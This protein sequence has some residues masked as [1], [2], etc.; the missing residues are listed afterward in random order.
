[1][2]DS[3]VVVVM[4]GFVAQSPS[5]RVKLIMS[6][7]MVA[8]LLP[9]LPALVGYFG[10]C[11]APTTCSPSLA[12]PAAALAGAPP[13]SRPPTAAYSSSVIDATMTSAALSSSEKNEHAL[14]TRSPASTSAIR[15]IHK[16]SPDVDLAVFSM[17]NELE[18]QSCLGA[19]H[20]LD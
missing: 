15:T 13:R 3:E 8:V 16:P 7:Y 6:A 19:D 1:M 14:V 2:S 18:V 10:L 4:A 17:C 11:P 12:G 9:E 5:K 20:S